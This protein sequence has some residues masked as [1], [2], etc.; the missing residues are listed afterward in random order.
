MGRVLASLQFWRR[1]ASVLTAELHYWTLWLVE[2][3]GLPERRED[4]IV[5]EAEE[6]A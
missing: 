3:K 1:M 5:D 4:D 6:S 2:H